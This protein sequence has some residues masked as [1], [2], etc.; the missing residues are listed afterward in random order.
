[1]SGIISLADR[2]ARRTRAAIVTAFNELLFVKGYDAI[3]PR[4]VAERA[5][6]GRSTFYEHYSSKTDVLA[7]S[8][9][10]ILRPVARAGLTDSPEP[11]L[12]NVVEHFWANRRLARTMLA[13]GPRPVMDRLLRDMIAEE[14]ADSPHA[15][16]DLPTILLATHLAHGHLAL[17]EEWLTGRHGCPARRLAEALHGM[18]CAVLRRPTVFVSV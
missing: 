16:G 2:R 15:G 1:M 10:G 17:I 4:E 8:L 11:A 14:I 12:V 6:I 7:Q 3:T 9:A 5:D 18:A 13:G